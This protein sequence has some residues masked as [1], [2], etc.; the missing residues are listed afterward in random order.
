MV[1][2]E[3]ADSLFQ[4]RTIAK[5]TTL[6]RNRCAYLAGSR[7]ALE[8]PIDFPCVRLRFFSFRSYL[9][10]QSLPVKAQCGYGI[11]CQFFALSAFLIREKTKAV[12]PYPLR[13]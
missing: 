13:Q 8:I 12:F 5:N 1:L 9:S 6:I 4:I 3:D 2:A 11:L 7:A 10:P